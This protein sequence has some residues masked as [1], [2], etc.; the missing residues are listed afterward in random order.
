MQKHGRHNNII[1]TYYKYFTT[2]LGLE[3]RARK[4]FGFKRR[5]NVGIDG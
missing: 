1:K 5:W 3:L 2:N 4:W